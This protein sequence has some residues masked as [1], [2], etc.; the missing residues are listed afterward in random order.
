MVIRV[1][2]AMVVRVIV[3]MIVWF[4]P[5]VVVGDI[6]CDW[7]T[8]ALKQV[9]KSIDL[10]L[11]CVDDPVHHQNLVWTFQ[12]LMDGLGANLKMFIFSKILN[13]SPNIGN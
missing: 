3:P 2:A 8:M 4:V 5:G 1:V 13:L 12:H 9:T 7:H 10:Q 11:K 6:L